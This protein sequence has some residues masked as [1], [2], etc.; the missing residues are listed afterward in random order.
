MSRCMQSLQMYNISMSFGAKIVHILRHK[1]ILPFVVASVNKTCSAAPHCSVR[2]NKCPCLLGKNGSELLTLVCCKKNAAADVLADLTKKCLQVTTVAIAAGERISALAR[3]RNRAGNRGS[4]PDP[5]TEADT[6][7]TFATACKRG[8][9]PLRRK[10]DA[11]KCTRMRTARFG[12]SDVRRHGRTQ[13]VLKAQADPN[14]WAMQT[15]NYNGQRFSKLDQINTK[16][17]ST[18]KVAWQFSTGV[19]R[20]HEGSPIVIGNTHVSP[21]GV[22]EQR[23]R[24]RTSTT[25]RRSS[26]ST[27][28]SRIR[29]SSP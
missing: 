4:T 5:I 18:L 23:V 9:K 3:S 2:R 29:R 15:G 8:K 6:R 26:G 27:R 24:S 20:G 7:C 10:R 25:S 19:L 13:S 28:R 17:V 11:Q 16:N 1:S 21:L 22:P 14:N 12:R